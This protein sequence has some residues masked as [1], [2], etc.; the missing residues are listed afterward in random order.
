MFALVQHFY[1]L[2]VMQRQPQDFPAS[3]FLLVLVA[4]MHVG[5]GFLGHLAASGLPLYSL[6]RSSLGLVLVLAGSW[7]MLAIFGKR[8]RWLQTSIAL[9][10]GEALI[11]AMSLPFLFVVTQ[12]ISNIFLELSLLLFL[13]WNIA[14]IGHVWRHAL[15]TSMFIG[16]VLA[17]GLIVWYAWIEIQLLPFPGDA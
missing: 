12:G 16:I 9:V 2:L 17:L 11:G 1:Q 3:G 8:T 7:L 10:G 14:F 4:A 6:G 15:E 13:V 5:L